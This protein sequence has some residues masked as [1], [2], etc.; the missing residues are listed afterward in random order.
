MSQINAA[1]PSE[2]RILVVCGKGGVTGGVEDG[3]TVGSFRDK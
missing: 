2:A 3:V 1:C